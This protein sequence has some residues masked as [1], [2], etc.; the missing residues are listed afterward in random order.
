MITI[1]VADAVGAPVSSVAVST[2]GGTLGMTD[3]GGALALAVDARG[4]V[5]L[6]F[7]H[8]AYVSES[9]RF[10]P[11]GSAGE[12]N[13]ALVRRVS[14]AGADMSLHVT[15][16]RLAVVPTMFVPDADIPKRRPNPGSALLFQPPRWPG[17]YAYRNQWDQDTPVRL[18]HEQ[19]LPGA[20]PPA[21][22][23]GW[24]NFA[25]DDSGPVVIADAGRFFFANYSPRPSDRQYTIALWSPTLLAP[26]VVPQLDMI[27]FFSPH[28]GS[29]V[30]SYPYGLVPGGSGVLDQPYFTLGGKYLL[31]VYFFAY[32][33]AARGNVAVIV[34]PLCNHGDWGPF[35]SAEGCARLLREV[36]A[37]LHRECR[38]SRLAATSSAIDRHYRLAGA[39]MRDSRA[40]VTAPDFG[41]VPPVGKV[42][43]SFFSSGAAPAKAVLSRWGVPGGWTGG[44]WGMGLNTGAQ[45]QWETSVRE[46]WDM[47]GY[48]PNTGGWASYLA[49]LRRWYGHDSSRGVHL[50]H[51]SGRAPLDPQADSH[52]FWRDL[53]RDGISLQVT[54]PK[55]SSPGWARELHTPRSTVIAFEN[56]Y[57]EGGDVHTHPVLGDAHHATCALAFAH[58]LAL[59][60]VGTRRPIS[61]SVSRHP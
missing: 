11:S 52:Q 8:H 27:M 17:D 56:S 50:C 21:A 19:L 5:A 1:A 33:A 26:N 38:T 37:F 39:S 14:S 9:V 16:A 45:A 32:E 40:P 6:T 54:I 31:D 25:S 57:I 3:S 61:S 35:A 44:Y 42:A 48:H 46:I 36:A 34:M 49:L 18:P 28:T 7:R 22:S 47:D 43:I 12:G 55:K 15:L 41:D 53:M 51:S 4:P 60:N 24:K 20:P 2:T 59:T 58:N 23:R 29:Y 13:N 10:A 30:G